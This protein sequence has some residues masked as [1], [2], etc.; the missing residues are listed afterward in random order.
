MHV[1]DILS[2]PDKYVLIRWYLSIIDAP[3]IDGNIRSLL[4]GILHFTAFLWLW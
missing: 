1:A 2:M 4:P 3:F